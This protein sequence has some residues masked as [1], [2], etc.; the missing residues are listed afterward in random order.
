MIAIIFPTL[1][2]FLPCFFWFL[3]WAIGNKNCLPPNS[4]P[5]YYLTTTMFTTIAVV[6]SKQVNHSGWPIKV[7]IFL[8]QWLAQ[9]WACNL[10][11]TDEYW[12]GKVFFPFHCFF[13][14]RWWL[15][16]S[17]HGSKQNKMENELK[18]SFEPLGLTMSH[19]VPPLN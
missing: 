4:H 12:E 13:V 18:I 14:G 19:T 8:I 5:T 1:Y 16:C 2:T 3:W 17:P 11:L 6:I 7:F 15:C 10:R 9:G